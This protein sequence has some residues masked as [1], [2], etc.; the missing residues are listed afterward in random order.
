MAEFSHKGHLHREPQ[1]SPDPGHCAKR[2]K[3]KVV[4]IGF[5][6]KMLEATKALLLTVHCALYSPF[7]TS[8]I[9]AYMS[10][11]NPPVL[12]KRCHVKDEI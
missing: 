4:R 10:A 9:I 2:P 12:F 7:Q 8:S 5:L 6:V 11:Q 1:A 3:E